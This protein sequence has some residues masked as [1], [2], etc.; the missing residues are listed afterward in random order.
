MPSSAVPKL[1]VDYV[2]CGIASVLVS[3]PLL[4]LKINNVAYADGYKIY[5]TEGSYRHF[6]PVYVEGTGEVRLYCRSLTFGVT[7]PAVTLTN[8]EVYIGN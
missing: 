3:N 4:F 7:M 5:L 1:Q 6:Y 2:S 8:I